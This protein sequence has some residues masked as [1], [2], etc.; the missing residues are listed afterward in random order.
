MPLRSLIFSWN[1]EGLALCKVGHKKSGC[2]EVNFVPQIREKIMDENPD[3]IVFNTQ[4][5]SKHDSYFHGTGGTTESIMSGSPYQLLTTSYQNEIGFLRTFS[6]GTHGKSLSLQ[7]SIYIRHGLNAQTKKTGVLHNFFTTSDPYFMRSSSDPVQGCLGTYINFPTY[8]MYLFLNVNLTQKPRQASVFYAEDT[9]CYNILAIHEMVN[10]FILRREQKPQH[11][12]MSGDFNLISDD[13]AELRTLLQGP[14]LEDFQ[15]GKDNSGVDYYP[16]ES[17]VRDIRG[18]Q[19]Q[20]ETPDKKCYI[21]GKQSYS[22]RCL[23]YN[24]SSVNP[25]RCTNYQRVDYGNMVKTTTAAVITTL[26]T[27]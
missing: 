26:T 16:T 15:E 2:E 25:L 20:T 14:I 7:T 23:Y 22:Q 17:L 19:C 18:T 1:G 12:I 9:R 11:V 13:K 8:G 27:D 21:D 6:K 3:V 10:T 5:M 24:V 4:G